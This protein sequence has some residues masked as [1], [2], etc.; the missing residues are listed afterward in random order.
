MNR[1][2]W[3][4]R[5]RGQGMQLARAKRDLDRC[6]RLALASVQGAMADGMTE[7]AVSELLEV[8]RTV[9]RRWLGKRK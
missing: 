3:E 5:L 6:K 2:Q 9:I 8:D 4:S 1:A 7:V